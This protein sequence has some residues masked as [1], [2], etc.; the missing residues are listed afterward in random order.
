MLPTVMYHHINSDDLPL[1]NS[2]K[3]M[4]EHL[5]LIAQRY[6]TIFP[7]D[8]IGKHSI[9]LTFDDAYYDF[10]YY[11]FPLLKKYYLKALL[12]VPVA[13]ILEDTDVSSK[14]RLSLKHHEIYEAN[15]YK[16]YVP[17]CTYSELREMIQSGHVI[18]ASHS[19]NHLNL[20]E[21]GIDLEQEIIASKI[22]LEEKLGFRVDSF[23]LHYGKYNEA[24][25]RLAR[26]HY[27]Y[28][29]RI[30]NAFNPSWNGIG[31]LLYRI[32]GDALKTPDALFN[33]F[34][35]IGFWIKTVVKMIKGLQ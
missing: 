12:A 2:H 26:K 23:V 10:Y 28:V 11:V 20:S 15:N 13:Y 4:E 27:S 9:C 19:M 33:P 8:Q 18:I 5:S 14:Q 25:I 35:R 7:G 16:T 22:V 32:K 24:V 29:F 34:R 6:V 21:E 17:F 31:G 1:S 3:M 30:G